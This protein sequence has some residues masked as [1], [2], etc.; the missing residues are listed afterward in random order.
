MDKKSVFGILA[1]LLLVLM[2]PAYGL[3]DGLV[4]Q[5]A[6]KEHFLDADAER[7]I[8]T[9]V[10]F[11]VACHGP[12]GQGRV[13]PQYI[14]LPL[15]PVYRKQLGLATLDPDVARKTIARGRPGTAMP[16]WSTEEDGDLKDYHI[17]DLVTFVTNWERSEHLLKESLAEHAP[18]HAAAG[19][20]GVA[21]AAAAPADDPVARGKALITAQAC[22]ACHTISSVPGAVGAVGPKLNG[23]GTTAAT[24]KPGLTAEQYIQESIREPTAY[25]VQGFTTGVMPKLPLTDAQISDLVAFL[26]TLK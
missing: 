15:N 12:D 10:Q 17:R 21:A 23:V 2:V 25:T 8:A 18:T 4:R 14:G 11:C 6:A 26:L 22:S 5:P 24:R 3:W 1:T 9:Y 16:A 19:A 7:G 20:A 13:E